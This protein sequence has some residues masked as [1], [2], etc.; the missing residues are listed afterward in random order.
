[1]PE[2]KLS[3]EEIRELW[4]KHFPKRHDDVKS[5]TLCEIF[6][7]VIE[8]RAADYAQRQDEIIEEVDHE[9]AAVGIPRSEFYQVEK[10]TDHE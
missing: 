8:R 4:A 7:L 6:R 2:G 10:E 3:D 5:Q 1:M 9:F